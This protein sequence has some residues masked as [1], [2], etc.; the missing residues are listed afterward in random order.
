[1]DAP[2]CNLKKQGF[3]PGDCLVQSDGQRRL[4]CQV[5]LKS[6]NGKLSRKITS[7]HLFRPENYLSIHQFGCNFACRKYHSWHFSKVA[8]GSWYTA[9]DILKHVVDYQEKVSWIE[10]RDKVTSF[11]A[12]NTCHCCGQ[13]VLK[14]EPSAVCPGI[15]H[16]KA[17]VRS[18]QEFGPVHNSRGDRQNDCIHQ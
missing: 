4:A 8:D 5:T 10:P 7:I 16:P 17:I 11:H 18:P 13:C 1:M 6:E 9:E 15:F 12:H 2:A 14:G 3:T